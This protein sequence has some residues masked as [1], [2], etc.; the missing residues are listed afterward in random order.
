MESSVKHA[1]T[2]FEHGRKCA[3]PDIEPSIAGAQ[4]AQDRSTRQAAPCRLSDE[5]VVR[6]AKE[7]RAAFIAAVL[8]RFGSA[9]TAKFR[10]RAS[11]ADRS[12]TASADSNT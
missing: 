6:R 1:M 10:L 5:E 2:T 8:R 7:E 4:A 9:L 12:Q 11:A 3:S